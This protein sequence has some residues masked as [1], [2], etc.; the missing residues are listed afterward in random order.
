[1][2]HTVKV[3]SII[4]AVILILSVIPITVSAASGKGCD[5]SGHEMDI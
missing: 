4:T 3:I 2:K 1:M 5:L